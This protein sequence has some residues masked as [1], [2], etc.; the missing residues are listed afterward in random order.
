MTDRDSFGF[1]ASMCDVVPAG[2]HGNAKITHFTVSQDEAD[3]HNLRCSF[4]PGGWVHTIQPGR[5][6]KLTIGGQLFMSDTQMERRTSAGLKHYARGRVLVAGLGLGMVTHL[7][8]ELP[9]VTEVVVLENSL[10]VIELVKGTLPDKITVVHA[11]VYTYAPTGQFDF[12]FFDIWP[13][14]DREGIREDSI[15]LRRRYRKYLADGPNNVMLSWTQSPVRPAPRKKRVLGA[16]GKRTGTPSN[17]HEL[18][19]DSGA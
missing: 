13:D 7:L 12:I 19:S 10:D 8:A 18:P 1:P 6:A 9:D 11:D 17:A 2:E 16:V 5:Y 14:F 3:L 15:K 4:R